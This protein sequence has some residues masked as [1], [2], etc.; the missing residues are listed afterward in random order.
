MRPH[1]SLRNADFAAPLN[2]LTRQLRPPAARPTPVKTGPQCKCGLE[3]PVRVSTTRKN[4]QRAF[5]AC[6]LGRGRG[7]QDFSWCDAQPGSGHDRGTRASSWLDSDALQVCPSAGVSPLGPQARPLPVPTPR[8]YR[9]SSAITVR[10]GS[11]ASGSASSSR[12]RFAAGA[13]GQRDSSS[14]NKGCRR[15]AVDSSANVLEPRR[16]RCVARHG[17]G[18]TGRRPARRR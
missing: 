4:P 13:S 14:S 15:I 9:A 10:H 12:I 5:R 16:I 1:G 7:C 8:R 11:A 6:P 18:A 3:M 17:G 2:L